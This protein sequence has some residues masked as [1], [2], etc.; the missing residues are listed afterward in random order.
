MI[1]LGVGLVGGVVEV[2]RGAYVHLESPGLVEL[3]QPP[4]LLFR[5]RSSGQVSPPTGL[6]GQGT[7]PRGRWTDAVHWFAHRPSRE[8]VGTAEIPKRNASSVRV[9]IRVAAKCT[10]I[11][12]SK[13]SKTS[14]KT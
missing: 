12:K 5:A 4:A 1:W 13:A 8:V 3:Q 14:Q 2:D 6:Q 9:T 10:L 7:L 11:K